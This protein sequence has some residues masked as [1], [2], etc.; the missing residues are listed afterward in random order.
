VIE[1]AGLSNSA[2]GASVAVNG[3]CLTVASVE[4]AQIAFDV[5]PET[6]SRSNLG[7]LQRGDF[8]N[9][10]P[11]LRL[12]DELGGHLVYGHVDA[13]AVVLGKHPEGQGY[14]MWCVTPP[15]LAPLIAEKGYVALDGVSLTVAAVGAGQFAVV[16]VPETITRTTLGRKDAG[17]ALN[18]EADAVARYVAHIL[19]RRK[20]PDSASK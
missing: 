18:L 20:P 6:L 14:R 2:L 9:V 12:G 3:V 15:A 13:T 16:L 5:V 11:S 17:A 10:E 4:G 7:E 8:V 1:C 19:G